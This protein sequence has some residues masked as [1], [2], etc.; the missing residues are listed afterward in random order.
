MKRA[1]RPRSI[2]PWLSKP[3]IPVVWQILPDEAPLVHASLVF[4]HCSQ[5]AELSEVV[6]WFKRGPLAQL[7]IILHLDLLEGLTSDEAGLRYLAS[8]RSVDGIITVRPHLVGVARRLG[9]ATILLLFLQDGLAVERGLHIVEQCQP[10]A[11][12]LVPGL[13]ALETAAE[14]QKVPVPRIAGG[15]V[16]TADLVQRLRQAGC[17]AVSTSNAKLW[18]LNQRG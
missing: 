5:L 16:R 9:L 15:L 10:D 18:L 12:E 8:L 11:L 2:T 1:S 13:A 7:P 14:F 4:L 6:A 3:V 17:S